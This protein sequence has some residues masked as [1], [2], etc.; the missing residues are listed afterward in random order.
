MRQFR[1]VTGEP[2]TR[3]SKLGS[4]QH[5]VTALDVATN[6][7]ATKVVAHVPERG[8]RDEIVAADVDSTKQ[9]S[10]PARRTFRRIPGEPAPGVYLKTTCAELS[11]S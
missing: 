9:R 2:A 8:H 1:I 11:C 6:A 10:K 7:R 4:G 5:Q 3:S